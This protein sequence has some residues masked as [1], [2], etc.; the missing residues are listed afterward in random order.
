MDRE[1]RIQ[2]VIADDHPIFRDGLRRLLEAEERFK[3][4]GEARDGAEAV[5][6]ARQLK[7]EIM[8][9]D[10]AMPR[11][12][13]LEALRELSS[14]S[15][16]GS[17]RVIL[18]TAAIEQKQIVEALQLG[19]RGIVMKDSATQ[20]LL[21]AIDAVLNGQYWVNLQSVS[22][23]LAYLKAMTESSVQDEKK[24]KF[25]LTPRELEIVSAVVAGLANKEIAA[26]FK[27]SEDTV[28]HH[29]SNIFDKLGVST[30]LELALFAVNQGLPLINIG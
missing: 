26:Y 22:N 4:I 8:L 3:V 13:G 9:L 29:L 2:L 6:L 27:I 18:L 21:K 15:E 30:R 25:G 7:P 23:L 14:G 11:H 19:A 17:V 12:P 24:R 10:L 16:N 1:G 20:V 5:K 28:K